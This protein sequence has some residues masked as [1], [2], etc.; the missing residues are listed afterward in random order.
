[1]VGKREL[2]DSVDNIAPYTVLYNSI[3]ILYRWLL[4]S[5]IIKRVGFIGEEAKDYACR[6]LKT[7]EESINPALYA[8]VVMECVT[9]KVAKLKGV[10]F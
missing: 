5:S 4:S 7:M 1:M 6:Y 2:I 8:Q 10:P 3:N 9:I